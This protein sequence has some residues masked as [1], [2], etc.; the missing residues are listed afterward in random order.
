MKED[1]RVRQVSSEEVYKGKAKRE[2]P[3]PRS[4]KCSSL[5][6]QFYSVR[7]RRCYCPKAT[8]VKAA[9]LST[10]AVEETK[11]GMWMY[12]SSVGYFFAIPSLK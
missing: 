5:S 7:K 3:N 1:K 6:T 4:H 8:I 10:E 12:T 11:Y 9:R 2:G